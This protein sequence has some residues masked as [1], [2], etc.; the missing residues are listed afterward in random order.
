VTPV[1]ILVNSKFG[2]AGLLRKRD[3]YQLVRK[4]QRYCMD[5]WSRSFHVRVKSDCPSVLAS[6]AHM[7]RPKEQ[8]HTAHNMV[9]KLLTN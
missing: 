1:V 7:K 8:H 6:I 5:L 4:K 3:T 2:L 9:A